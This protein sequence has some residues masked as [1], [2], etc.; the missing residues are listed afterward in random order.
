MMT[1]PPFAGQYSELLGNANIRLTATDR[2]TINL[3]DATLEANSVTI[4]GKGLAVFDHR[5]RGL[6]I[7]WRVRE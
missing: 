1:K 4:N 7:R 5:R 2:A 6:F 3:E